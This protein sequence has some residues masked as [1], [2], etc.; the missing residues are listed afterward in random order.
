MS[1]HRAPR[2][3]DRDERPRSGQLDL[4]D[5]GTPLE[6]VTFVVVDLETTGSTDITEIGAVKLRSGEVLGE[7]STLVRPR[8]STISPFV[9]RLTGI[10]NGM[11]AGAPELDSVLPAFLE[12][13]RGSVLVAHN[14]GFDIG[15]LKAA[16]SSLDYA[17]PDPPVLDTVKLARQVVPRGEVVNHK[18]GTLAAHFGTAV[19]PDHRALADAR[20]TGEILHR[21]FD[22]FGTFGITTLEDLQRLKPAGWQKRRTKAHL[23]TGVPEGPGV[24]MFLDGSR[25]VLYIG[26]SRNMRA[27]VRNYF[28][29]GETRG[30]MAEMITAAQEVSTV[31]CDTHLEAEVREVRLIGELAPPYN[32][33]SKHPERRTWLRLT[34]EEFPRL[35]VVR[36]APASA[37]DAA[38]RLGPFRTHRRAQEAKRA[39][40]RLFPLKQCTQKPHHAAFAPC[41]SG[42]LGRCGGPCAGNWDAEA[43]RAGIT[44]VHDLLVG[45][46]AEF[47]R[48]CRERMAALTADE[49]FETAAEVRDAMTGLLSSLAAQERQAGLAAI[50]ECVAAVP[51][52]GGGW[53]LA[54]VRW[55]RL[56]GSARVPGGVNPYPAIESLR[57]TA[58]HVEQ[59]SVDAPAALAQETALIHRRL[60]DGSTRLVRTTGGWSE[61]LTGFGRVLGS[62]GPLGGTP[63]V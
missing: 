40:D 35:S 20:A 42:E 62:F 18:L 19:A 41:A 61:P 36:T 46:P 60:A 22:R 27:R 30:R 8:T 45:D 48:R 56:A 34:D 58:E 10:T 24:Y 33:R 16:C 39:L 38:R 3:F 53:D 44:G 13:A 63:A 55:G 51:T 15:Y 6:E 25:R 12:F 1:I 31:P 57:L 17:W 52:P 59:P 50:E 5:L 11:V 54:L 4:S 47:V 29:A 37:D 32:R 28:T 9:E 23:A 49:R 7:F 21:L 2:A 26:V 14:A 43:Y